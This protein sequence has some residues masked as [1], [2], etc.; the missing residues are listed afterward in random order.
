MAQ[1]IPKTAWKVS[2]LNKRYGQQYLT[3]GYKGEG[4]TLDAYA[5]LHRDSSLAED[6]VGKRLAA[7]L[8]TSSAT[9]RNP[10]PGAVVLDLRDVPERRLRPLSASP[11][12]AAVHP[13][14]LISG[15]AAPI[16]PSSKAEAELFVVASDTQRAV[17]G[18]AALRRMGY[19]RVS[20]LDYETAKS[21]L[22]VQ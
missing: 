18:S 11:L 22:A 2:N 4:A 19:A 15:A 14:D 1:W 17:N 7:L 12:V 10:F 8:G 5:A 21:S 13:H 3:K 16:L 20:V 9:A 6:G